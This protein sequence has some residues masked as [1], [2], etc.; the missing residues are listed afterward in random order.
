MRGTEA[1]TGKTI[2]G[3]D[4]LRQSLGDILR[5]PLGSRVGRRDYGS[6]LFELVDAPMNRNTLTDIY[7]AV[8]EALAQWEPRFRLRQCTV[9]KVELGRITLTLHGWYEENAVTLADI[10]V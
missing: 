7:A 10:T 3:V 1:S 6:R 5:T 8:A 2:E 4:H 9:S